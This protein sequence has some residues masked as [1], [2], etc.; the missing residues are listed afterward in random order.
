MQIH[1]QTANVADIP[2]IRELAQKIWWAHYPEIISDEQIEYMLDM[3]Y[4]PDSL[5]RQ[6]RGGATFRLVVVENQ[7]IGFISTCRTGEGEYFLDKFYIET[8]QHRRGVGARVFEQ[9]L[10]T[11]PDLR[12]LRLKV[13][14]RNFRS[15]NFYFKMGFFIE[16]NVDFDIGRG[17]VMDD[18][19]MLFKKSTELRA[20]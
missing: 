14:R 3:M 17:W 20:A 5:E 2:K 9:V 18:F 16:K 8:T 15:I 19:Q 12:E 13:N 11:M 7:A 6:L 10:A 1:L 4:S